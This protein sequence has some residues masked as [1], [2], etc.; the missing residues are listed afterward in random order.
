[1][2]VNTTPAH[3]I[4]GF[5]ES[6][7]TVSFPLSSITGLTAP[8]CDGAT[9]DIREVLFRINTHIL[10]KFDGEADKPTKMLV[11][12]TTSGSESGGVPTVTQGITTRFQ[13]DYTGL[14]VQT[15]PTP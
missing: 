13:L 14:S 6:G 4:T 8:M 1:M 12:R 10:N 9:G 2:A 5:T 3:W 7:G 15:E 11:N